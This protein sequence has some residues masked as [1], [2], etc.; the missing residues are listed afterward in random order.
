M[1]HR[2]WFGFAALLLVMPLSTPPVQAAEKQIGNACT[3]DA[4]SADWD[5]IARC[6]S[7]TFVRAPY[8][9]GSA[10]GS[11]CNS[12]AEGTQRYNSTSKAMEFCNGSAWTAFVNQQSTPA[13]TAPSGSGYFVLTHS[14]WNGALG[15]LSGADAKCLT[16]LGTT[17]TSWRGYTDANTRG[18][19]TAAKVRA[20]LC[21]NTTCNNLMPLTTYSFAYAN[22]GTPGGAS[23]TTD[24]SGRGPGDSNMWSAANY[25]SGTYT[26]W[27]SRQTGSATLWGATGSGITSGG[28]LHCANWADNGGAGWS[29]EFGT[30]GATDTTRWAGSAL[31]GVSRGLVCMVNP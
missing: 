19:I 18:L 25:F 28:H 11:T 5:T 20:W 4:N 2:T 23:F 8:F 26:Y 12:G 7:G 1:Y 3:G 17:Y 29:G 27:T 10:T 9:F 6:E 21:D 31:C 30:S 22:S 15:G 13:I 24:S 16:E 14:T